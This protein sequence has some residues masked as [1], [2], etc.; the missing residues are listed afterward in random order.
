MLWHHRQCWNSSGYQE[1]ISFSIPDRPAYPP[2]W[3]R[4]VL[5]L[6]KKLLSPSGPLWRFLFMTSN[7]LVSICQMIYFHRRKLLTKNSKQNY[8]Y[9]LNM[10]NEWQEIVIHGSYSLVKISFA[11]ICGCKK[12]W[13]V[14]AE[15]ASTS[16]SWLSYMTFLCRKQR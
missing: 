8:C 7:F 1:I 9:M 4:Q 2:Q 11:Q 10:N 6:H 12:T 16:Q 15:N 13:R 5:W 3:T 14:W